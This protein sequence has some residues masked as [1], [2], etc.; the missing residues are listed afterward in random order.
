MGSI[1]DTKEKEIWQLYKEGKK[2]SIDEIF[3]LL[4][5]DYKNHLR[6]CL[7]K[8]SYYHSIGNVEKMILA[9][10]KA[11]DINPSNLSFYLILRLQNAYATTNQ[12]SKI[13]LIKQKL[14]NSTFSFA[15][16]Y[17]RSFIL[18]K[19]IE[20]EPEKEISLATNKESIHKFFYS[21]NEIKQLTNID[22]IKDRFPH[23]KATD[24]SNFIRRNKDRLNTAFT[25]QDKC[26]KTGYLEIASPY[27]NKLLKSN[28]SIL[29]QEKNNFTFYLFK[30][31]NPFFV[32]IGDVW[33]EIIGYYFPV[34]KMYVPLTKTILQIEPAICK[35]KTLVVCNYSAIKQRHP[36]AEKK[37]VIIRIHHFAHHLWNEL[38][39][40]NRIVKNN[41]L[42]QIDSVFVLAQP[43]GELSVIFKEIADKIVIINPEEFKTFEERLIKE[44]YQ[45]F[46]LGDAFITKKMIQ[47]LKATFHQTVSKEIKDEINNFNSIS[48]FKLWISIR[49]DA[50]I[51]EEQ[52]EG[53]LKIIKRLQKKHNQISVI[54]DGYSLPFNRKIDAKV[55]QVLN[56]ERIA[57]EALTE[58]LEKSKIP[59]K[60]LSGSRIDEAILW[61]EIANYYIVHQGTIQHKIAWFHNCEGFIHTNSSN[62]KVLY[63]NRP[64]VWER[65]DILPPLFVDQTMVKDNNKRTFL[66]GW[67]QGG[68]SANYS[69]NPRIITNAIVTHIDNISINKM[70]KKNV[71]LWGDTTLL[72]ADAFSNARYFLVLQKVHDF[73]E[74]K[75]CYFEIGT[76][77][78]HSMKLAKGNCIGVDPNFIVEQDIINNKETLRLF[79]TTSDDFFD[80]FADEAF[81]K[82][83]ID[84]AFIDGLHHSNQV[85]V[86]FINSERYAHKDTVFFFH[87]VLPRTYETALKDRE[88]RM[89]TG[90]VWKAIWVLYQNR[91]DLDFVFLD[92]PPSGLL[93]VQY[94]SQPK[95]M[96]NNAQMQLFGEVSK[97]KDSQL[98][99]YLE[100]IEVTNANSF[101]QHLK[102]KGEM[103]KF[104]DLEK[105]KLN[106]LTKQ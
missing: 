101:I 47:R 15:E 55:E 6:F 24:F 34:E 56:G 4:E 58:Q 79:Q 37:C 102:D 18:D 9:L 87:D 12:L 17:W 27:N 71:S 86:D 104:N 69:I 57:F 62:L 91:E 60:W 78:G 66:R 54:I 14:S 23:L 36:A 19:K 26:I 65:E 16:D 25:F 105:R 96:G 103:P 100:S 93:M 33:N 43:L 49:V 70:I 61:G 28:N 99:E 13:D 50:K 40:L 45:V 38:S 94:K 77:R 64:G 20:N 29:I 1:L 98:Y 83:N 2:E 97:V 3:Q 84:V 52:V 90:D 53:Y 82:N 73:Y 46:P 8:Q 72:N 85:F 76:N 67:R 5:M 30:D 88:T 48:D 75:Y 41:M 7:I 95:K 74:E 22:E 21:K 32:V 106:L 35:L 59:Y 92:A 39:A 68:L 42:Q 80:D 10:E 51:W 31:K 44:N 81:D 11:F 63:E 89:W